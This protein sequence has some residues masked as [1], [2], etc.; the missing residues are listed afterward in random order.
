MLNELKVKIDEFKWLDKP[1]TTSFKNETNGFR[2]I[3]FN[4]LKVGEFIDL[5]YLFAI[6]LL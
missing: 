1:P 2:F 6:K 5:D 4:N 3:G